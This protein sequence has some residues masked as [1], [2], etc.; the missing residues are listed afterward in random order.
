MH[1]AQIDSLDITWTVFL[2]FW[3]N[4]SWRWDWGSSGAEDPST[5][6]NGK[7]PWNSTLLIAM[8]SNFYLWDRMFKQLR[9]NIKICARKALIMRSDSVVTLIKRDMRVV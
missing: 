8:K 5:K 7:A 1:M 6:L 3:D 2:I 9:N 4:H